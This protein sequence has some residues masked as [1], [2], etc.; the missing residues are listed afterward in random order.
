MIAPPAVVAIPPSVVIGPTRPSHL[1]EDTIPMIEHKRIVQELLS[2]QDEEIR[3]SDIIHARHCNDLVTTVEEARSQ[4]D[5]IRN[6]LSDL[7]TELE[8]SR[9]D[10]N[11]YNKMKL[12]FD[13]EVREK[14]TMSNRVTKLESDKVELLAEI[15]RLRFE[16]GKLYDFSKKQEADCKR[17]FQKIQ[18][19]YQIL[20]ERSSDMEARL[21]AATTDFRG[22]ES[23]NARL[24]DQLG[25]GKNR[26]SLLADDCKKRDHARGEI[27]RHVESVAKMFSD[28]C[29][30]SKERSTKGTTPYKELQKD[31]NE[32]KHHLTTLEQMILSNRF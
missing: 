13:S 3:R 1:V 5:A 10:A 7:Q 24:S 20:Q 19:D 18:R 29:A 23:D 25:L 16:A 22:M 2:T 14:D 30:R 27:R 6:Q 31:Q 32:F 15:D 21:R 28:V 26:Y 11:N 12:G 9:G 8:R 17:G 4:R